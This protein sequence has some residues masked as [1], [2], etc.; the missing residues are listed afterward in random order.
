MIFFE[1]TDERGDYLIVTCADGQI[2]MIDAG[3]REKL[4]TY[5]WAVRPLRSKFTRYAM[6]HGSKGVD[7]PTTVLLHRQIM[8]FPDRLTVDHIDGDP[9]NNR[10]HNLRICTRSQNIQSKHNIKL[11][12]SGRKGVQL[13][14]NG[15]FS[16]IISI[17]NRLKYLGTFNDADKAARVWDAAAFAARGEFA[18]LNFPREI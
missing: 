11:G 17:G 2:F 18:R 1:Y 6:R 16:A 3:D 8:G 7:E 4:G 12:A 14:K 13:L 5:R 10:R 15:Q 9:L